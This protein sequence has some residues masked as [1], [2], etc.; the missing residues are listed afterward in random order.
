[1]RVACGQFAP[2]KGKTEANLDRI[3]EIVHQSVAE[4][5]DF[6]VFPEASTSGYFL[7][8]GVS[9]AALT[10]GWL[11][12]ALGRRIREGRAWIAVGHYELGPDFQVYNSVTLL[13]PALDGA[14]QTLRAVHTHRKLFLPT[15]GVFDEERFVGRGDRVEVVDLEGNVPAALLICEDVWHSVLPMVAALKGAH[16]LVVPSASPG[17]EFTTEEGIGNHASYRRIA[18]TISQEHGVF[19]VNAQLVGFEGG[20][21]LVGGSLVTDPFG[22]VL[23]EAP[24]GEEALL[25][26]DLDLDL[27]PIA[28]AQ[29]PM[30]SDLQTMWPR[31]KGLLNAVE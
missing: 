2:T 27:V 3:A 4:G 6:V 24:V 22:R 20:K 10:P 23:A 14:G 8:G 11:A 26:A 1:M 31:V 18:R 28:R 15:Y 5:A 7:E 30:L 19:V 25:V 13:A 9:A 21:G 17:R 12:S 29:T 16:V